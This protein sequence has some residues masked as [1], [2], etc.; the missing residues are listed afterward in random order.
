[1]LAVTKLRDQ[2][3]ILL[4]CAVLALA[5]SWPSNAWHAIG[6]LFVGT[7][8]YWLIFGSGILFRLTLGYPVLRSFIVVASV[9]IAAKLQGLALGYV[10]HF[11]AQQH[12]A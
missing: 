11:I 6:A 7:P 1:M 4:G 10:T 8:L 5:T 12:G 3:F 9:Y 2:C